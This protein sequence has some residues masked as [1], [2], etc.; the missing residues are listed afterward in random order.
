MELMEWLARTIVTDYG[1]I[2]F[3]VVSLLLIWR[4]IVAPE[5]ERSRADWRL[6]GQAVKALAAIA[7]QLA[8][9]MVKLTDVVDRLESLEREMLK[10]KR[11]APDG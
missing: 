2:A 3:G 10:D 4:Q 11:R 1:P 9:V 8:A 5:L 7:S 6:V